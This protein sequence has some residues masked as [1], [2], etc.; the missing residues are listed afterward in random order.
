[1]A[2]YNLYLAKQPPEA[3]EWARPVSGIDVLAHTR[4]V[5]LIDFALDLRPWR[6]AAQL[7]PPGS[8]MWAIGGA[9]SRSRRGILLANH[10]LGWEGPHVI[11][12]VQLTV[13]GRINIA[14]AAFVGSPV[15]SIGFNEQ[16][17]WSMTVNDH[18]YDCVYE[19]TLDPADPGKY[20]YDGQWLPLRNRS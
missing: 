13:P 17:G 18:L 19:L 2:G 5:M 15:V 9:R 6:Q 7:P 4:A 11:Q 3:P 1:A 10:H 12:E 20:L 8:N 16:L 14:G